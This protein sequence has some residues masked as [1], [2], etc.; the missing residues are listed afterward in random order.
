MSDWILI[1]KTDESEGGGCLGIIPIII[2][3]M[4]YT[5]HWTT[6]AFILTGIIIAIFFIYIVI[7]IF[8][9]NFE[10]IPRALTGS[11]LVLGNY[12]VCFDFRWLIVTAMLGILAMVVKIA[13]EGPT[14]ITKRIFEVLLWIEVLSVIYAFWRDYWWTIPCVIIGLLMW[15]VWL[16]QKAIEK[17]TR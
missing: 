11:S 12:S 10:K 2:L 8:K 6:L 13:V 5:A 17:K 4:M 14:P 1:K 9:K 7:Q 16:I 3:E 15:L